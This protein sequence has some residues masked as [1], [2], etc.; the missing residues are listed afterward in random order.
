MGKNYP[1]VSSSVGAHAHKHI[2]PQNADFHMKKYMLP[3]VFCALA[4]SSSAQTTS[5]QETTSNTKL[6]RTLRA[7]QRQQEAYSLSHRTTRAGAAL[8]TADSLAA[9]TINY[10][11]ARQSILAPLSL[12]ITTQPNTSAQ[13]TEMLTQAGQHATTISNTVVTARVAP[14]W[15]TTLSNDTRIVRLTASKRLRPFLQKA[16]QVTGVDRV[17]AGDNLDTPF[18]GKGIVI[19]VIDQSFEFKHM[20]FLDENGKSRI[21]MLWDRSKDIEKDIQSKAAPVYNVDALTKTHETYDPGSGH[22]THVTNIAAGSKHADNP[23]YGV[24]PKADIVVIPSSFENTEIIE[25]IRAVKAYASREHKPWVANLSLGS[26]IGPHDGSTDYDQAIDRMAQDKGGIVVGAMG[27]EGDQYFHAFSSFQPGETKQVFVH[28]EKDQD[29]NATEDDLTHIDFWGISEVNAEQFTVT[30]ILAVKSSNTEQLKVKKFGADFWKKYLDEGE[31]WSEISP[32]NNRENHFVGVKMNKLLK[33]LGSRYT[34]IILG[35]EITAK[36]TNTADATLHGWI[37]SEE[38]N[39]A[40][41]VKAK[42]DSKFESIKPDNLYIVGEGGASIPSAIAVGSFT[43]TVTDQHEKEGAHST[44]SSNGPW[45]NPNYPK[46]AV[47]AP[48]ASIM[49]ALNKYAPGFDKNNAA[50]SNRFN[51][52]VYHYGY[53]EGTSMATPFVAGSI[54]LWLEANP[55][56][57]Y[58]DVLDILKETSTK[59]AD[60]EGEAWTPTYGYGLINVYEGLKLALKKAGKD[61]LTAIERVSGSAAPVTFHTIATQWQILFNN[62]ERFA[63][64]EVMSL[65][66]RSLYR[67]QLSSIAQGDEVNIPT[68]RFTPGV[69]VLQ[70]STSG[71]KIA[72]KMVRQ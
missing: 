41:F 21:K 38:P 2:F 9:P 40:R 44:F 28:Y 16:R 6:D 1:T 39:N 56:L 42:T 45:L 50:Y 54:A 71:A 64:L 47:L 4:L 72:Q 25:D 36:S 63:T 11:G 24:A 59:H 37:Y 34:K 67:Q 55:Q 20:G 5:T 12:I 66:G 33:D 18:T 46:P 60:M 3:V 69:Y 48:G 57:S 8:T 22:G 62:P 26:V 68:D 15:L 43:T 7:V 35:V 13:V 65:D 70:V 31:V 52:K 30:P 27:N 61:P 29:G 53:M 49:S 58:T 51:N 17:H 14:E 10:N 23:F 32:K 19:G